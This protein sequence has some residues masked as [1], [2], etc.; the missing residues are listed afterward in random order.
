MK[1]GKTDWAL[2]RKGKIGARSNHGQG[3]RPLLH[4]RPE[5]SERACPARTR[6]SAS[7]DFSQR[8]TFL[9]THPCERRK[10]GP[11][12]S[13]SSKAVPPVQFAES[14][15]PAGWNRCHPT[16]LGCDTPGNAN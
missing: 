1:N 7:Q 4:R 15:K 11:P 10:D 16:D 5:E 8:V 12:R 6:D 9:T 2:R 13:S 3:C 14:L